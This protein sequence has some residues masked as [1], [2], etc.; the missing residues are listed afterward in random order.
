MLSPN[1]AYKILETLETFNKID[2]FDFLNETDQDYVSQLEHNVSSDLYIN[3]FLWVVLVLDT[4][5]I[6]IYYQTQR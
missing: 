3:T 2:L 6:L 4:I 1:L 5:S